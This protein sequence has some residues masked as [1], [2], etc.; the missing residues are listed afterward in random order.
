MIRG[1]WR[2]GRIE[3]IQE[4]DKGLLSISASM[5]RLTN[6]IMVLLAWQQ[7]WRVGA[8]RMV[9]FCGSFQALHSLHPSGI[10]LLAEF[11]SL[12]LTLL[13]CRP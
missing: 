4:G 9:Q 11:C 13:L 3:S 2:I 12:F 8:K 7:F 1:D 10:L 5:F 6:L